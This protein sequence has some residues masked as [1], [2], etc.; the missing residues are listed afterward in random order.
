MT[1]SKGGKSKSQQVTKPKKVTGALDLDT[2]VRSILKEKLGDLFG[3]TRN[4]GIHS[5]RLLSEREDSDSE[6]DESP[7]PSKRKANTETHTSTASTSKAS[8]PTTT[9]QYASQVVILEGVNPS[10]KKHPTRLSSAFNETKPNVELMTDGLRITASGDVLVKPKN[11]KDCNA[12]LK[13]D[14]FPAK[15]PLGDG[16]KARVPKSQQVTHQVVIKNVDIEV[17]Q[18]EMDEILTRQN[19]PYKAVKRIHS[20]QRD[21]PTTL[22][23]L[24][25]KDEETKKRLLKEG[26]NLDQMH[27]KCIPALEDT[28]SYPKVNQCFKCQQIGDHQTSECKNDQKCVLCSGPHRKSECTATKDEHKCANCSLGHAS[29]SRE[30]RHIQKALNNQKTPTFAQIA[31]ATVT[32]DLLQQILQEVKESIVMLITEVVA[33]SIC[34]LVYDIQEKNVSKLALPMRVG[35]I[36]SNAV[37]AANKLKFGSASAPLDKTTIKDRIVKKCF[38]DQTSTQQNDTHT[39][40]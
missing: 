8:A 5:K 16:V 7:P 22:F 6:C 30:C 13:S 27:Y 3:E 26:I 10:I 21:A 39:T 25:L 4:V 33:R 31:S 11:P 36:T 32:P 28:R 20:R 14:A 23:R 38:P 9:K 17:T 29:W 40:Q 37:N 34:E 19:L 18:E 15:C 1:K 12:L 35:T 2:A 24:I